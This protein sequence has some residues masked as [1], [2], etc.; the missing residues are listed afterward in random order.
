MN[1][2]EIFIRPDLPLAPT[3]SR[4]QYHHHRRE[5][6]TTMTEQRQ[7]E[8]EATDE[9]LAQLLQEYEIDT[10][11]GIDHLH[12]LDNELEYDAVGAH[13]RDKV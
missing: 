2:Q 4:R 3:R 13:R 12:I 6:N 7:R 8:Q 9:A 1:V 10:G 11:L 5:Q